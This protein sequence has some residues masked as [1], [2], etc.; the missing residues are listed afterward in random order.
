MAI[1]LDL[2]KAYDRVEWGVLIHIMSMF[3]FR[4]KFRDLVLEC[5]STT[6]FSILLNGS[7]FGYFSPGRGLRQ[8]D[9]MSPALFTIF[10]DLMS[11]MLAKANEDGLISG[12]KISCLSPKVKHLMYADD[13]VVYSKATLDEAI[14]ISRC[15]QT[16]CSWT[17]KEIN[18]HK[19]TIHFSS[20]T[21]GPVRTAICQSM[22]I[23]ECQHKERYLG[24]P[25]CD[26]HSK[27]TIY[28]E[29]LEKMENKI[30]GWKK[31][32]LLM[33]GRTI[34]IKSVV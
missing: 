20:N 24:H 4:P 31:R 17:S 27:A 32:A 29:L 1:K 33:A 15:L 21:A 30:S 11:R 8:G 9:P 25:L 16:Y 34:L 22:G 19:S 12:V 5:I 3:G 23:R 10:F 6:K 18:W 2:A 14:E 28:R 13:L 7:P 26:F